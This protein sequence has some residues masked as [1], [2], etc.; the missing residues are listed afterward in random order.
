MS[1]DVQA[2]VETLALAAKEASRPLGFADDAARRAAV[3]AMAG[4]LRARADEVLS[5]N[6]FDMDAARAAGT[7]EGLLD[8]LLLTPDRIESMASGLEKLA[9]LP[10]PVGRILEERTIDCGLELQKVSVPTSPPTPR[11]SAFVRA[12]PASCAAAR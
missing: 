7:N 8:R 11:A 12:T 9:D 1:E 2:Y 4:A 3:R 6:E 10:D 5:A